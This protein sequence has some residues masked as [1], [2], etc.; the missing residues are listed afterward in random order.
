MVQTE[1]T[2]WLILL[3][4]PLTTQGFQLY[5]SVYQR[6]FYPEFRDLAMEAEFHKL[7]TDHLEKWQIPLSQRRLPLRKDAPRPLSD[8]GNPM[9]SRWQRMLYDSSCCK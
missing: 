1:P 6:A 9:T 2:Y 5:L 7:E 8:D 4:V 3:L